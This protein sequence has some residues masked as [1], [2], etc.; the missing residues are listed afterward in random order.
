MAHRSHFPPMYGRLMQ[1]G[2]RSGNLAGMLMNIGRHI[3]LL[4][5]LR[6]AIYRAVIYVFAP[7][8]L[9]ITLSFAVGLL[10]GAQGL[11]YAGPILGPVLRYVIA[12]AWRRYLRRTDVAAL[13]Y[14]ELA[15]RTNLPMPRLLLA[16]AVGES[17]RLA[18]PLAVIAL[19]VLVGGFVVAIM[20]PLVSLIDAVNVSVF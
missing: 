17:S 14:L 10:L 16:G 1:V 9:I 5:R 20:L 19:A 8:A 13:S 3:E 7:L 12:Q 6:S 18:R 2:V 15:A 11:M 4:S